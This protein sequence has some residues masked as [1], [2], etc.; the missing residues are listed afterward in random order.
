MEGL[1]G[2]IVNR[3]FEACLHVSNVGGIVHFLLIKLMF[4]V[5]RRNIHQRS[6]VGKSL[7]STP[8]WTYRVNSNAWKYDVLWTIG[9]YRIIFCNFRTSFSSPWIHFWN[10]YFNMRFFLQVILLL[11]LLFFW[12]KLHPSGWW[13]RIGSSTN[14]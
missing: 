6:C 3:I 1:S 2:I 11:L 13:F 14:Q 7:L 10:F 5:P 4:I 8:Y 12:E 9:S